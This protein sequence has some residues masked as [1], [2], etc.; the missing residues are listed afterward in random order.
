[1]ILRRLTHTDR[2]AFFRALADW[3]SDA[4]ARTWFTGYDASMSFDSLLSMLDAEHKGEGSLPGGFVPCTR[5]YAFVDN[6]IIG[7]LSIRHSLTPTLRQYGGNI[8]YS[9]APKYRGNGYA[10]E[11][12]RLALPMC[13]EFGLKEVLLTIEAGNN[14]S[15]RV[16][17][18][19]GGR[20]IGRTL[21]GIERYTICTSYSK[22]G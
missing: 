19:N 17:E 7:R 22:T 6:T 9:I 4:E 14:A 10:T 11:M 2:L 18:K 16:I 12:L 21:A 15:R 3:P 20:F 13:K 5:L 8:G 1:M